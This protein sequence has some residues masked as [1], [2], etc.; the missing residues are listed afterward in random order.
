MTGFEPAT[1][2]TTNEKTRSLLH[3]P[4]ALFAG[5]FQAQAA[6]LAVAEVRRYAG[7]SGD[8]GTFWQECLVRAVISN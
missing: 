6:L 7:I 8:S 5:A 1:A 4:N 2:W 3:P